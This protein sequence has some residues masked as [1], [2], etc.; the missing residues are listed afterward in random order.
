MF[1]LA[2]KIV[3][4]LCASTSIAYSKDMSIGFSQIGTD[5]VPFDL[6]VGY[7]DTWIGEENDDKQAALLAQIYSS[8][9]SVWFR[10]Y[11]YD[12]K[13]S[14]YVPLYRLQQAEGGGQITVVSDEYKRVFEHIYQPSLNKQ[15]KRT[16][17]HSY[18]A[19]KARYSEEN[20]TYLQ[21]ILLDIYRS[22]DTSFHVHSE[23]IAPIEINDLKNHADSI[24]VLFL[25]CDTV[26]DS[27]APCVD[28]F[29]YIRVERGPQDGG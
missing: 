29:R 12:S 28:M 11:N 15:M 6:K 7:P 1:C 25:E 21:D 13:P 4:I 16:Y 23:Y 27:A 17:I 5:N 9:K 14:A 22:S 2:K 10:I 8:D 20:T 3:M 26:S 24:I 18:V 19:G